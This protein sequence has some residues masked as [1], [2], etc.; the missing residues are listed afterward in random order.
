MAQAVTSQEEIDQ[1]TATGI[2]VIDFW[3]SWCGPCKMMDPILDQLEAEYDGKI[4]FLKMNVD[5][6]QAIA[7]QYKVMGIPSLVMFKD[8]KAFEKVTG[9][10]PKE[11]LDHYFETKLK[12]KE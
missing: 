12:E 10:Y 5:D 9:V 2:S 8:G 11:K 7:Q 4:N 3:A 1:A 6:H